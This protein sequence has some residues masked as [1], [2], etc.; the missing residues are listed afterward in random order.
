MH[1]R[2][3]LRYNIS[4]SRERLRQM[5]CLLDPEGVQMRKKRRL[6]RRVYSSKGPNFCW[7]MDVDGNDKILPYGFAIHGCIDGFS[8]KVLWLE[9]CTTNKDSSV[10][11]GYYLKAVKKY[12]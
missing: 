4:I 3:N 10:I 12:G 8:R 11:A 7:H 6:R 9:V 1:A 2:L 5:M